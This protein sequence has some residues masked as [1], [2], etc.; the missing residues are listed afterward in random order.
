MY[1]APLQVYV[2]GIIERGEVV[3]E[4]KS[5][6]LVECLMLHDHIHVHNI[7]AKTVGCI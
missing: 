6:A 5:K 3:V 7:R 4:Y 2:M 1:W